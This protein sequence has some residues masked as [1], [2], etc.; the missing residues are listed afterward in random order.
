M[1]ATAHAYFVEH[2]AAELEVCE[3]NRLGYLEVD[4]RVVRVDRV[5]GANEPGLFE[6]LRVHVQK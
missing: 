3:R 5:V 2:V 6:L 4:A 1:H